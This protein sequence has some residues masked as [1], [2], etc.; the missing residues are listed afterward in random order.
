MM[1]W[2]E[3]AGWLAILVVMAG[4]IAALL[5]VLYDL[6]IVLAARVRKRRGRP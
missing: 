5:L 4:V 1:F 2:V 6:L 3:V